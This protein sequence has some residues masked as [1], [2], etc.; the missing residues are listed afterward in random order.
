MGKLITTDI[1]RIVAGILFF[2]IFFNASLPEFDAIHYR[3]HGQPQATSELPLSVPT[4]GTGA[5]LTMNFD[6]PRWY[7]THYRIS[8]DDCLETLWINGQEV[9]NSILPICDLHGENVNLSAYLKS[10]TNTLQAHLKDFGGDLQFNMQV[11]PVLDPIFYL[12][13]IPL[14]LSLVLLLRRV[15][16]GSISKTI[17]ATMNYAYWRQWKFSRK[18]NIFILLISSAF[19]FL[20]L[21]SITTPRFESVMYRIR[22]QEGKETRWPLVVPMQGTG[23][24]AS[25]V[26]RLP[27]FYATRYR[28]IPDDC[29][30]QLWINEIQVQSPLLPFCNLNGEYFDLSPYLHEG[31]NNVKVSLKDFGGEL[32]FNV[33]R[34]PIRDPLFLIS[35]IP[36]LAVCAIVL[37]R[38]YQRS[39]TKKDIQNPNVELIH[40]QWLLLMLIIGKLILFLQTFG[41]ASG[42]DIPPHMEMVRIIR[43]NNLLQDIH[44]P[45]YAYHP[46]I[47]FLL[48]HTF[49]TLGLSEVQSVQVIGLIASLGAFLFLRATLKRLELLSMPAAIFFLYL[50]GMMPIQNYLQTS[51]N[52]DSLILFYSTVILYA[53]VRLFWL[54]PESDHSRNK[55]WLILGITLTAGLFTKFS[56]VLLPSIPILAAFLSPQRASYKEVWRP[57]LQTLMVV[58]VLT[59]PYYYIRYQRTEHRFFPINVDWYASEEQEAARKKRDTDIPRFFRTLL[60]N[61]PVTTQNFAWKRVERLRIWDLWWDFWVGIEPLYG[62]NL[63]VALSELYLAAIGFL[64]GIFSCLLRKPRELQWE[65]LGSVL[66]GLAAV[67]VCTQILYAYQHPYII[68]VPLKGIYVAPMLLGA[69]FL[70]AQ[71]LFLHPLSLLTNTHLGRRLLMG[72]ICLYMLLNFMIP[73]YL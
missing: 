37:R 10:G 21:L 62:L 52:L 49:Y 23:A 58:F 36:I 59:F 8:P 11:T 51:L 72:G 46:P 13:A 17:R 9:K 69:S 15:G 39:F 35:L 26:I 2:W 56:G 66:L 22:N 40:E 55:V 50:A 60:L 27:K 25:T 20:L 48:P 38:K 14:I 33:Q 4:K 6:L 28:I 30:Q 5:I 3:V 31:S 67:L 16:S 45:F 12:A 7:P 29:L 71:S 24:I 1:P 43:W 42:Q 32:K 61:N 18:T 63:K 57:L 44:T 53:S 34:T 65:R 64:L 47:G 68:W 19:L 73:L 41:R 70:I 54:P